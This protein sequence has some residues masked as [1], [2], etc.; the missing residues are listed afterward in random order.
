MVTREA[1]EQTLVD[2]ALDWDAEEDASSLLDIL[3]E[4]Y[5]LEG[6]YTWLLFYNRILGGT[7]LVMLEEGRHREVFAE[8]RRLV[9]EVAS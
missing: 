3:L 6:A 7:P 5:D 8:A 9:G 4:S 2:L 1:I